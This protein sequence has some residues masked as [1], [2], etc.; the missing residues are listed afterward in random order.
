MKTAFVTGAGGFLGLNLVE[1]LLEDDWKVIA[2]DLDTSR[3]KHFEKKGAKL[4]EGDITNAGSCEQAMPEG[5]DAVFHLASDT[6]HWKPGDERQTRINVDGTRI[7]IDTALKRHARR[8]IYTSSIG[9]Y[10]AQSKRITEDTRS[11]AP[12]SIINYWRNKLSAEQKIREAIKQGLDAVIINPANIIGPYDKSGWARLFFLIQNGKLAGAPPGSASFCHAREVARAH[13]AAFEK[14][15]SGHNYL[16]GGTDATWLEFIQQIGKLLGEKTPNKPMPSFIL[17]V[18]GRAS[19]WLSYLTGKEP[20][21]TPEKAFLV[22]THLICSSDKAREELDYKP[23]P[24]QA[25]LSDCH[26]WLVKEGL[27]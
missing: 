16:L 11:T 5:V 6:V 15:R 21:L 27:L 8:F 19:L 9:A 10:G 17:K 7:V 2:F 3:A 18:I 4:I 23:V 1:Q 24:L 22:S 13:I 12:D 25:M 14:G 20:D 26:R